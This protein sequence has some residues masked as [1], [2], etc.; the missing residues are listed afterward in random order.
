MLRLCASLDQDTC[1]G[2]GCVSVTGDTIIICLHCIHLLPVLKSSSVGIEIS[3]QLAE[4]LGDLHG[5]QLLAWILSAMLMAYLQGQVPSSAAIVRHAITF[6][7][8]LVSVGC[9]P[10][11]GQH[12]SF[13]SEVIAKTI[14]ARRT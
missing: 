7:L 12:V 6:V 13:A 2:K 1:R 11:V 5:A 8:L 9:T 3:R 4:F 10:L 14:Q